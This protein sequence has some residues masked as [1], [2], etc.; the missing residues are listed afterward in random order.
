VTPRVLRADARQLPLPDA[1]VDL[2]VTSPPYYGLR[3]YTDGGQPYTGQI[4][5]EDGWQEWL[6]A[7]LDA[8][9]EW[10]RVLK[11]EGSIFVNL[12]D[13]YSGAQAQH[14]SGVSN[15]YADSASFWRRTNPKATGI[16]AKSLMLL[17]E[18]YRIACLDHGLVLVGQV[19]VWSKINCLPES[20]RDR[21]HRSHEDWVHL[22]RQA[23]YYAAVDEIR[24][25]HTGGSHVGRKDGMP[26]PGGKLERLVATGDHG[27]NYAGTNRALFHP[28][29]KIPDSVWEIPSEPLRVPSHVGVEHFAAFPTEWP[30]RLILG[31]S[32]PGI[33]VECG[34]GRRPVTNVTTVEDRKG[35]RQR[36]V[37]YSLD[38]AHGP[39]GRGGQRWRQSVEVTGYRC[40]CEKPTAPTRPA[41]VLDPFGGTGTTALVADTLGRIGISVDRSHDYCRL[42]RW[43]IADL[44]ERAHALRVGKPPVQVD[45]QRELF[46]ALP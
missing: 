43:R 34:R 28:I 33:C 45:G 1:S 30:R 39:D 31:W 46:E 10:V 13:K 16:A 36:I 35:R 9:R 21:A 24:E 19:I 26:P 40:G 41:V 5:S 20:V 2:V 32:P 7:L 44:G 27:G 8:T 12:G 37:D 38:A 42:A 15:R 17:P 3:S 11:P 4:G 29:G 18:R 14:H 6:G 23:H 22:T 25:P